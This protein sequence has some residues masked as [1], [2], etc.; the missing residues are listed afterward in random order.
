[1]DG[2]VLVNACNFAELNSVAAALPDATFLEEARKRGYTAPGSIGPLA[3]MS[4]L[5]TETGPNGNLLRTKIKEMIEP[6]NP[7]AF[8]EQIVRMTEFWQTLGFDIPPLEDYHM[9]DIKSRLA[10]TPDSKKLIPF[11]LLGLEDWEKATSRVRDTLPRGTFSDSY[12]PLLIP[13]LESISGKLLL[14]PGGMIKDNTTKYELRNSVHEGV[15]ERSEAII[16]SLDVDLVVQDSNGTGWMF[17]IM[18]VSVESPRTAIHHDALELS[19]AGNLHRS[20]DQTQF[21]DALLTLQLLHIVAGTPNMRSDFDITNTGI[22]EINDQGEA[23]RP[24]SVFAVSWDA[25]DK[26][27]AITS[28]DANALDSRFGVRQAQSG[29]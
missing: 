5:N 21:P 14:R 1:M 8:E 16:A 11:P 4:S 23:I 27:I 2:R 24:T 13:D 26:R 12:S 29:I 25:V 17:P 28:F 18:D 22:Y 19:A 6:E 3:V 15:T 9:R 20:V 7:M 10:S